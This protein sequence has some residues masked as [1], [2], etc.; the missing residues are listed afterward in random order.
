MSE[1]STA[2]AGAPQAAGAPRAAF[3]NDW[4]C[5]GIDVDGSWAPADRQRPA[6][7]PRGMSG[8]QWDEGGQMGE[9]K[10]GF[11]EVQW[12]REQS[13]LIGGPSKTQ[14]LANFLNQTLYFHITSAKNSQTLEQYN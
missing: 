7:G 11:G 4:L 14:P 13:C 1:P 9:M 3:G 6:P 2:A 10:L 5:S 12:L 8:S